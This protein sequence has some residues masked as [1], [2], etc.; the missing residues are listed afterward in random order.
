LAVAFLWAFEVA[1]GRAGDFE[2]IYGA[3]GEWARLFARS[4]GYLGTELL[5]DTLRAGRYITVDRWTSVAAFEAFKQ[6]WK[7]EY[8]A[9]DRACESLTAAETPLGAF[10]TGT[11]PSR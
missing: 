7:A 2:R 3:D 9:L 6:E 11:R 1:A 4:A 5:K 10:A 8:A